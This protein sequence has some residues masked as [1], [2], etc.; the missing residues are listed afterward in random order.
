MVLLFTSFV[1]VSFLFGFSV[2]YVSVL[3]KNRPILATVI[4]LMI[5]EVVGIY[6]LQINQYDKFRSFYRLNCLLQICQIFIFA[7]YKICTC[8]EV[9]LILEASLVLDISFFKNLSP[10]LTIMS[11]ASRRSVLFAW[12]QCYIFPDF[13]KKPN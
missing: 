8:S 6:S 13:L 12:A 1:N 3:L 7:G 11:L 10:L 5:I 4:W 9:C 2:I